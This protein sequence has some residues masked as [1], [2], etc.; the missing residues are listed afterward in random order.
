MWACVR[1][2][3]ILLPSQS[4]SSTVTV[5]ARQSKAPT[6]K[7]VSKAERMDYTSDSE[8][9][10]MDE[11]VRRNE[12]ASERANE[13]FLYYFFLGKPSAFELTTT[14]YAVS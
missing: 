2:G 12:R 13:L 4:S 1:I 7:R 10:S 6:L 5:S 3:Y 11:E 8:D 9:I 14:W